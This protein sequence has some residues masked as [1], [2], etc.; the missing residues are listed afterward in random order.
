MI[1]CCGGAPA[2]GAPLS[3]HWLREPGRFVF[4]IAGTPLLRL[5]MDKIIVFIPPFFVVLFGAE[6]AYGWFRQRNT[7]R[8]SDALSSL[9]QGLIS[10]LLALVTQLFQ[11]GL[12]AVVFNA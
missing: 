5:R 3:N 11:I 12:Y 9:S 1:S 8:L 4:V 10:Q 2:E 6:F 7:Y